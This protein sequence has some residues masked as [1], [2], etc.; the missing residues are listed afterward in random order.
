MI[1]HPSFSNIRWELD[2]S[3]LDALAVYEFEDEGFQVMAPTDEHLKEIAFEKEVQ[4]FI[5]FSIDDLWETQFATRVLPPGAT[6]KDVL[7]TIFRF[8]KS[9]GT[10]RLR[11]RKNFQTIFHYPEN[12]TAK[13]D[14]L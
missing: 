5:P 13:V 1:N 7:Q 2:E 11:G 12:G 10:F 9:E 3:P 8:Y 6:V 4:L 14:V